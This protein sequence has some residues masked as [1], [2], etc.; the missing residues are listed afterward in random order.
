MPTL[1]VG[2]FILVNKFAYG[3][4]L[5]VLNKKIVDIGEPRR[6]DVFVFRYPANPQEDYI[7]RVIGLPGDEIAYRNTTLYVNG[8]PVAET[9]LGVYTGPAE[10]GPDFTSARVRAEKL[11]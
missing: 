9:D 8:V 5:P 2:D 7:K 6:G 11:S 4:R 1:L 3:L 10:P